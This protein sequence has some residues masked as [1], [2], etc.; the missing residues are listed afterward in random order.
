LATLLK[1]TAYFTE[2]KSNFEPKPFFF[3]VGTYMKDKYC[4][5]IGWKTLNL[6]AAVF[7]AI[8]PPVYD[9]TTIKWIT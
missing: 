6:A 2:K 7:E 8:C 9:V 1:V 4:K 3:G 5:K